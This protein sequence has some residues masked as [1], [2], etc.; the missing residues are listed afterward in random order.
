MKKSRFTES[1]PVRPSAR[2]RRRPLPDAPCPLVSQDDPMAP[3]LLCAVACPGL[4]LQGTDHRV[5]H[6]A[7]G[8]SRAPQRDRSAPQKM[9]PRYAR[10]R[11]DC[12]SAMP[13]PN[14]VMHWRPSIPRKATLSLLFR[15]AKRRLTEQTDDVAKLPNAR[16][17]AATKELNQITDD[18]RG[19]Q[20]APEEAP[21]ANPKKVPL[22]I[23]TVGK[24]LRRPRR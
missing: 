16:I 21:S 22:V 7:G 18:I 14:R 9:R 15:G 12:N 4:A 5:G 13:Q 24:V 19:A 23:N 3:G 17:I 20:E 8:C 11:T 2:V 10:Y 1:P 6:D